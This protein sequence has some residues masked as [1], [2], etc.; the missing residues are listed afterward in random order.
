MADLETQFQQAVAD[1]KRLPEKP[2]NLTLLK[3]YG[4]YKQANDGDVAGDR[5]GFTDMVQRAKW[6]AWSQLRGKSAEQ[7]MR[8]YVELVESLK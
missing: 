2:D 8:E 4:L 6:D 5:P 7:S 3:L 1:S